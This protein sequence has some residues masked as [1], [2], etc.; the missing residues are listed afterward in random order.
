MKQPDDPTRAG[1]ILDAAETVLRWVAGKTQADFDDD[2]MLR[3]AVAYQLQ[4]IGEA[5]SHLSDDFRKAHTE[6]PWRD[7]IAMR[8]IIVHAYQ[9][10]APNILWVVATE[11]L[12]PLIDVVRPYAPPMEED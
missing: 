8:N 10:V 4:I 6:I 7:V 1:H 11:R 9:R 3:S 2:D 5:A 12:G